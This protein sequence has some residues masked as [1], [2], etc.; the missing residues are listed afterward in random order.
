VTCACGV[1]ET[2]ETCCG[3][4]I[5]GKKNAPTAE[6]LMRARY[7]AYAIGQIDFLE[8]SIHPDHRDG[9]DRDSTKAW[10]EN[11][12]WKGLDIIATEAGGPN[13]QKG[14][15]EFRARFSIKGVAQEHHERATFE[16]KDQRWYFVDGELV[17]QKPVTREGPRVG[18]NDACPCGSGKKYKKCCGKAA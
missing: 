15:V 1:G 13:D 11:A 16:R 18:R 12:D 7:T 3:P 17:R 5:E 14:T 4:I 6:A 2:T 10:S 9:V 8:E